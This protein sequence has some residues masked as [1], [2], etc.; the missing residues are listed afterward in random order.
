MPHHQTVR[1]LRV[2]DRVLTDITVQVNSVPSPKH[3][4]HLPG[5]DSCAA[6]EL[7]AVQELLDLIAD[8]HVTAEQARSVIHQL[9]TEI[10]RNND[11]LR[12]KQAVDDFLDPDGEL[13]SLL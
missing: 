10:H 3:R 1:R 8:G 12:G 7:P 13:R 2:G 4:E 9:A 11:E 5:A 6:I